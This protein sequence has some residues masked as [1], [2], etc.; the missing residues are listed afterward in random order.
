MI[1][2][3]DML[4]PKEM[5]LSIAQQFSEDQMDPYKFFPDFCLVQWYKKKKAKYFSSPGRLPFFSKICVFNNLSG[6][7]KNALINSTVVVK[8][9]CGLIWTYLWGLF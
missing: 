8:L 6:P 5:I 1:V 3:I 2:S 4:G 9:A 7:K